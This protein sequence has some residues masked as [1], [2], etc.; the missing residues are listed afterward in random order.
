MDVYQREE[1][2]YDHKLWLETDGKRGERANF[3]RTAL[4]S[5][6]LSKADLRKANFVG[7]SLIDTD[8]RG[9][10]LQEA[11]LSAADLSGARLK[12]AEL[13]KAQFINAKLNKANFEGADLRETKL[14]SA[15][16]V[17]TNFK[18]ANIT[19]CSVYGISAWDLKINSKTIQSDLRITPQDESAVTVDN[20]EVAQFVYLLLKNEKIKGAIDTIGEKGVLI[21]GR[22]SE[23]RKAVLDAIRSKLRELGFLPMM[24]DF[25]RPKRLDYT[26]TIK[27]LAGISRFIIVDITDPMS[28]P[29]ELQATMP[30]FKIPFV[31]IIEEG[32]K[33]F[34][35][36][37][38]LKE[39]YGDWL[40]DLLEYDSCDNLINV[41]ETAVVKPALEMSDKILE[42]KPAEIKKRHVRE[43]KQ[44]I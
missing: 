28:S 15:D 12:N 3:E 22:F 14:Q 41:L 5:V 35:M 16:L 10:K 2:L 6:N 1:I 25:Q 42:E 44:R 24:F 29:L 20:I 17:E 9:A 31:P 37:R 4:D 7:A 39:K 21:L 38:D 40:L 34:F 11:N 18:Y 19:G 26:G 43:F 8:F 36:L 27:T 33:R 13:K 23:E 32:K 30:Y